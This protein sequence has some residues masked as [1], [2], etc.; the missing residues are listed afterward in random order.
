MRHQPRRPKEEPMMYEV[1]LACAPVTFAAL[2][3]LACFKNERAYR[4]G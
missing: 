2:Y 4:G 3:L 1:L